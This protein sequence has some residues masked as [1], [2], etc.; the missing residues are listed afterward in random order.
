MYIG[1]KTQ[2][3]PCVRLLITANT[4]SQKWQICDGS[5]TK[6]KA[7]GDPKEGQEQAS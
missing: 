7:Q 6:R 1:K 2:K 4:S 3:C 5:K